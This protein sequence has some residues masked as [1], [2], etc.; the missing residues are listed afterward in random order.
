V[1][2]DYSIR[3]TVVEIIESG[4]F[5]DDS[6]EV[7]HLERVDEF[8]P[9]GPNKVRFWIERHPHLFEKPSRGFASSAFIRISYCYEFDLEAKEV[10][11]IETSYGEAEINYHQLADEE[12]TN[13]FK[14]VFWKRDFTESLELASEEE[15]RAYAKEQ[16]QEIAWLDAL[17][18][19][20]EDLKMPRYVE[21]EIM[22]E[23]EKEFIDQFVQEWKFEKEFEQE[24]A[25]AK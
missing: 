1:K 11:L 25:R 10:T 5:P 21:Q 17:G 16:F 22:E 8:H 9:S 7:F 18:P 19:C 23:F 3:A 12:V 14:G 15:V 13:F 6:L 2:D 20:T 4:N 24:E